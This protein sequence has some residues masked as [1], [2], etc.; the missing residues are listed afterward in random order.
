MSRARYAPC[1]EEEKGYLMQRMTKQRQAVFA[2]LSR[3]NDF[4]SAQQIFEDIQSQGQ[5][6]GLATVYRNLQS[7]ADEGTVDVLRSAEGESLFRY[8]KSSEH[9]H[10]LV[11]RNC[12]AAAEIAQHEIESWVSEVA[13]AHGYTDVSHS[14]ELFGL[15][16]KCTRSAE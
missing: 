4:R 8:C 1:G 3:V 13:A 16:S 12:G 5:R 2:E 10:H 9:H 15:C 14:M 11:C 6:V 7:L